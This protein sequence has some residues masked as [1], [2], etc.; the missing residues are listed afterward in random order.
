MFSR[1]SLTHATFALITLLRGSRAA[2][3]KALCAALV[4]TQLLTV[5]QCVAAVEDRINEAMPLPKSLEYAKGQ[6]LRL[7]TEAGVRD[8]V[9]LQIN[10]KLRV[11]ALDCAQGYAPGSFAS[12]EE[13]AAHFG[14]SD[15]FERLDDAFA[16]WIGWRRVGI[17]IK[18]PPIR[19]IPKSMPP[20]VIGSD[21]I[22]D[23]R[24]ASNAGVVLLWTNRNLEL[25]DLNNGRRV[26]RIEGLGGDVF[27]DVSPNGRVF[28]TSVP[29]G[30]AL[31]DVESGESLAR[32]QS[33]FPRDFTWLG[34][35]RALIHRAASMSSF[36]VEFDSGDEHAVRFPKEAID[37]AIA[38]NSP[39]NEFFALTGLSALRFRTGSGRSEEPL[40]LLDQKPFKIQN[41]QR[42]PGQVTADGRFF[43]IPAQDLN[44]ISTDTLLTT[45]V[46][47]APFEIR[48]VV[49]LPN[50]DLILL[51]GDNP[52]IDQNM[53]MRYYVY[54]ISR[55]SFAQPEA[56]Y[57]N[58]GRIVYLANIRKLGFVSQNRVTLLDSLPLEEAISHEDFVGF[59]T[60]EQEQHRAAMAQ[61]RRGPQISGTG[62]VRVETLPGARVTML[63]S[64]N[65]WTVSATPTGAG[66]SD[67]AAVEGIGI[68]QTSNYVTKPDGSKEGVAIVHV[69]RGSGAP[70]S[71]VLSSHEAVRWM[72]TI[73]R[74]AVVR[75]IMT[76]GPKP[77]EVVGM[78]SIPVT[79]ITDTEA[80]QTNTAEYQ[81]LETQVMRVTG[82][83]IHRFQGALVGTEFTVDGR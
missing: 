59:V 12:K 10:A 83:R 48:T 1:H 70:I 13:I 58:Q 74:G 15:C 32:V 76:A 2:R 24:F 52:G 60:R 55:Q 75:S 18:M 31:I 36:T 9:E 30:T 11:R 7:A 47:V 41:W 67:A 28:P 20:F 23:I 29:G 78:G 44:F 79:H 46:A 43:V 37:Q 71:L 4:V 64:G 56:A 61:E 17:L 51:I 22:Q 39:Q 14:V 40:T 73:E 6:L 68:A 50:P 26:S 16:T 81:S 19:P 77:A 72:I 5:D 63:T 53:G 54:S 33:I 25:I 34:Q 66:S 21:Y 49:P 27:G 35:D 82:A 8:Q 45:T 80:N 62:A 42:N 38:R 57:R 65:N 3:T 69:K